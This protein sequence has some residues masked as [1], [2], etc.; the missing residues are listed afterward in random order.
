MVAALGVADAPFLGHRIPVS[1]GY[2]LVG[3]ARLLILRELGLILGEYRNAGNALR[4]CRRARQ[5][6]A[7]GQDDQN[8]AQGDAL[9]IRL[10]SAFF[11]DSTMSQKNA[12]QMR[13][14]CRVEIGF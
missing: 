6:Q 9:H 13:H 14:A 8:T 5:Q 11:P 12:P 4:A 1:V 3:L 7:G 2:L 10:L